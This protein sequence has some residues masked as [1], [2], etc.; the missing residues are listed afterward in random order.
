MHQF[1]P[2]KSPYTNSYNNISCVTI[3]KIHPL[4]LRSLIENMITYACSYFN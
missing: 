2:L 3:S 4:N 1:C